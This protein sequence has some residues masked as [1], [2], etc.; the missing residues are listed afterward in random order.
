[1]GINQA[2]IMGRLTYDPELKS[3]ATG[4]S[5]MRFQVAVDRQYQPKGQERQ[6]DFIDCVAWEKT[7]EFV[8]RYFFK[9][10]MIAL[11]GSVQTN[12]FTDKSGNSRKSVEIVC[13]NVSFCGSKENGVQGVTEDN[14]ADYEEII[15]DTGELPF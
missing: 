12:T 10:S 8:H 2:V 14:T 6:A 9:G 4:K 1:M 7:A 5:V 15:E 13:N 3:S 11:T